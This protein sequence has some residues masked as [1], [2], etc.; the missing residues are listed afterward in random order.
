M[1]TVLGIE[2]SCDE[3]AAAVVEDGVRIL[4]NIVSSQVDIH[5]RFGGV[6]PELASRAHV[7]RILPVIVSALEE[8]GR[9][10]DGMDCIAVVH[11]PGLIGSVLVGVS[12]AKAM[13][14]GLSKPLVGVNHLDAHVYAAVMTAPEVAFPLVALVASGGHTT[15]CYARS[16]LEIERVGR[17]TDDAAG[18]AFDK[19]AA[20]LGLPYPGGPSIQEAAREGDPKAIAFPRAKVGDY[21]FSFSGVKTACLYLLRGTRGGRTPTADKKEY[22]TADVAASFQEAIVDVLVS[23]TVKLATACGVRDVVIG[24]GVACNARLRMRLAEALDRRGVRLI[25]PAPM[26]CTDNAAMVAGLGYELFRAGRLASL[27]LD[28]CAR[29]IATE[30]AG[31]AA[32]GRI[33]E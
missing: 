16:A 28:A 20:L 13:A 32:V 33:R 30:S 6:V 10:L 1:T 26:L 15:L 3:T 11:R 5:A 27:D 2:T 22:R 7:E 31:S 12:A 8:S 21:D 17:T 9:S 25:A 14:W 29:D 18:E 24:G 4:S 23:R 19:A